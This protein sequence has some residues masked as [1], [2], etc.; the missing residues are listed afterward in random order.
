MALTPATLTADI[1]T[2]GFVTT[3]RSILWAV[4]VSGFFGDDEYAIVFDGS[5][6]A[7]SVPVYYA[8]LKATR[9]VAAWQPLR[10]IIFERGIYVAPTP[11]TPTGPRVS[12]VWSQ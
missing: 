5:P 4:Y 11:A 7:V 6:D 12:V 1:H 2:A 3:G 8:D 10:G 9:P